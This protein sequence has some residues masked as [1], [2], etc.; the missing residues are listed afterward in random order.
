M[1]EEVLMVMVNEKAGLALALLLAPVLLWAP[2]YFGVH[3]R[4]IQAYLSFIFQPHGPTVTWIELHETLV[5][6]V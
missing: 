6:K 1:K 2:G 4:V 5:Y 3:A